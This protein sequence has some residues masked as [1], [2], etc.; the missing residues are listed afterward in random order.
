MLQA[1]RDDKRTLENPFESGPDGS[2]G[3][4]EWEA[5]AGKA[6]RLLA[7]VRDKGAL[8]LI[9]PRTHVTT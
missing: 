2:G 6:R 1:V 9:F 7:A 8:L 4:P 3:T 5:D